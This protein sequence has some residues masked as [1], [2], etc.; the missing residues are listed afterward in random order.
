MNETDDLHTNIELECT[1]ENIWEIIRVATL[2]Q[3][4]SEDKQRTAQ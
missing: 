4:M 1:K 2:P 3:P